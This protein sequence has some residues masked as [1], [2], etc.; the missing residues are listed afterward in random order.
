MKIERSMK[1]GHDTGLGIRNSRESA[2]ASNAPEPTFCS[3]IKDRFETFDDGS[4]SQAA[5]L[6]K[7]SALGA[8]GLIASA[9]VAAAATNVIETVCVNG[10][11]CL[12]VPQTPLAGVGMLVAGVLGLGMFAAWQSIK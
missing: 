6:T 10:N 3:T 11:T 12:P 4:Q 5:R 2:E 8:G 1:M 7:I 9:S